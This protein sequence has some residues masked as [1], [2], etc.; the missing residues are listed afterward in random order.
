MPKKP[1]QQLNKKQVEKAV[2]ALLKYLGNKGEEKASLLD[3]DELMY[4]VRHPPPRASSVPHAP[5]HVRLFT[6]LL[7]LISSSLGAAQASCAALM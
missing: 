3:D 2:E 1:E 6:H 5:L 4:L 7:C